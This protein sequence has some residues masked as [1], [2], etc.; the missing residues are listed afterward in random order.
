MT[1][2]GSTPHATAAAD[3]ITTLRKKPHNFHLAGGFGP[4]L[5]GAV[6]FVLML[7]LAPSVAPERDVERPAS[8]STTTTVVSTTTTTTAP[9]STPPVS[10]P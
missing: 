10:A 1:M 4:A 8:S 9:A 5:V 6:L 3:A 7:I 2:N